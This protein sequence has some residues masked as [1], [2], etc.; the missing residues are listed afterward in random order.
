LVYITAID[1]AREQRRCISIWTGDKT[2]FSA[3]KVPLCYWHL[4]MERGL[5]IIPGFW[6]IGQTGEDFGGL[7]I[8]WSAIIVKR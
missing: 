2:E 8:E 6:R 5:R 3:Q 1:K 7:V 4:E